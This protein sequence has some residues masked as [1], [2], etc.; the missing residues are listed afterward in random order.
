M[1]SVSHPAREFSGVRVELFLKQICG[2]LKDNKSITW[3]HFSRTRHCIQSCDIGT[4][5]GVQGLTFCV[6]R[7]GGTGLIPR[8]GVKIL[9]AT[10]SRQ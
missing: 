6:P 10:Q 9:P 1:F 2:A 3:G 7:A 8:Q 4:P 5:L